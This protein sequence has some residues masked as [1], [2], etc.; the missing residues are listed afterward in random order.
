[1]LKQLLF[2]VS[3]CIDWKPRC[4]VSRL[5]GQQL[6]FH[7]SKVYGKH[8]LYIDLNVVVQ[9]QFE[10]IIHYCAQQHLLTYLERIG[11]DA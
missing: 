7:A 2:Q 9:E 11:G 10:Y 1:M 3:A 4:R 6:L 5:L 8:Q